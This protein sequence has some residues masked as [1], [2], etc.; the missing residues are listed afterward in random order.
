MSASE[1]P[2]TQ[3]KSK[4]LREIVRVFMKYKVVQNF[5]HL[6]NPDQVRQAFE[7]LGPTFI[8]IGQML[9]VRTD[10]LSEDYIKAFKQLQDDV[11][12]DDFSEVRTLLEEEWSLPISDIFSEFAEKPFAS[13]SIGQAHRA[14]LKNGREV[15]VKV[16]HPGIV[17]AI[18]VDLLLFEKAIPLIRY[19]PESSVVDLKSVLKE[20]RTSLDNETDFLKE[21]QNAELFYKNNNYWRQIRV[22]KVYPE[23][24]T[25]KVVVLE[26]M[27]GYKLRYLMEL[28][29]NKIAYGNLSNR[30]LKKDLGLLLVENFMKQVFE[31]GFFHADPHPGNLFVHLLTDEQNLQDQN[32][33]T[34]KRVGVLGGV[35]YTLKWQDTTDLPPYRLIFLDFGMMG[36]INEQLRG[37]LID[38]LLALYTQDS[39]QLGQAVLRLCRQEGPFEEEDFYRELGQFLEK[40]YNLPI[41]DID[42]QE[43]LFQV[44]NICHNNNLQLE[45]DVTMLIKALSTLEGVIEELDPELSLM[46]VTEPYAQKYFLQQLDVKDTFK[47]QSLDALK[48][49]RALPK[50]PERTLTALETLTQGKTQVKL[51]VKDQEKILDRIE[52][53]VNRLVIGLILAAI[54]VGSSMLVVASPDQSVAFVDNL[55]IFG[56][57]LALTV[58]IILSLNFLYHK[59]RR[60]K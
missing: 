11:K 22:T 17:A 5:S 48:G 51:T 30:Q 43:V 24:S 9:S 10:L 32:F 39:R 18:N 45:E 35:D 36:H 25:K 53:M 52:Q 14:T 4:R 28:D 57:G 60:K 56:F 23:Y 13:A 50:L 3:S 46:E 31:D 37:R 34:K 49:L 16:Q 54:I 19:I 12:S 33:S 6:T 59:Y 7:E 42:L 20:V 27:A 15:V 40:Y 55:G 47:R 26:Y 1:I 21:S 2:Q 8:K 29:E 41:K 44:I 58:I 38:A